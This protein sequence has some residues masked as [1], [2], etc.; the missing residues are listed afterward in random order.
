MQTLFSRAKASSTNLTGATVASV[1]LATLLASDYAAGALDTLADCSKDA[2]PDDCVTRNAVQM[3]GNGSYATIVAQYHS[4]EDVALDDGLASSQYAQTLAQ[5][6]VAI[7]TLL[8]ETE[9]NPDSKWLVVVASSHG[10]NANGR[11]DG[12]PEVPQSATF[13]AINQDENNG[14]RGLTPALPATVAGLYQ[15]ASIAD[16]TPTMLAFLD[17]SPTSQEYAMDGGQLIGALPPALTLQI[18]EDN[19]TRARVLLTWSA[20]ASAAIVVMRDGVEIARL[21]TGTTTYTDPLANQSE[22]ATGKYQF[23]YA[24]IAGTSARAVPTPQISYIKAQPPVPLATTLVNGLTVYYPF[25]EDPQQTAPVDA[26]G[27]S[28][29]GRGRPTPTAV[30]RPPTRWAVVVCSSILISQTPLATTVTGLRHSPPRW[31]WSTAQ[32]PPVAPSP[33]AFGTRHR[34]V[35]RTQSASPS[36]ATR[37]AM[38]QAAVPQ[39]SSSACSDAVRSSTSRTAPTAPTPTT[40]TSCSARTSGCTLRWWSMSV[41]RPCRAMCSIPFWA[42][43]RRPMRSPPA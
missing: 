15:Y 29:W 23:S 40:R 10:L 35:A 27:H 32:S 11:A 21:P 38:L 41:R 14:Q 2:V 20:T 39:A 17:K 9:R 28:T 7:G 13:I 25:G 16:V 12:L 36:S 31:T 3:I 19:T 4:A 22:L 30:L 24:V 18:A 42:H 33:S 6:D 34:R 1:P 8:S 5:L 26:L 43:V 37:Q